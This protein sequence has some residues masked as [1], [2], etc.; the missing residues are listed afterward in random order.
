MCPDMR[1]FPTDLGSVLVRM[2]ACTWAQ[3]DAAMDK[4]PS[5][6]TWRMGAILV[7]EGVIT[8]EAHQ[9]A[10]RLQARLRNKDE[11]PVEALARLLDL[12]VN[13]YAHNTRIV[14]GALVNGLK[15]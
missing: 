10:L 13:R 15:R 8:E 6:G 2:G 4:H 9:E 5:A 3:L 1:E 7:Q 12:A 11:V 14:E